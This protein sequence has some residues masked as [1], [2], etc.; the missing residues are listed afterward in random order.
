[1]G[2]AQTINLECRMHA[3]YEFGDYW[4]EEQLHCDDVVS[5]FLAYHLPNGKITSLTHLPADYLRDPQFEARFH[6]VMDEI[7]AVQHP[8]IVIPFD[9]GI[10]HSIPYVAQEHLPGGTLMQRLR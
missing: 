1:M 4:I 9:Y 5:I 3:G 10:A 6:S 8:A 2:Q 7:A